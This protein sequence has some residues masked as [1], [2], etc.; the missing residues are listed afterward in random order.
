MGILPCGSNTGNKD[1]GSGSK[2][3]LAA[4]PVRGRLGFFFL[5][6]F[7]TVFGAG[8]SHDWNYV[9]TDKSGWSYSVDLLS[10]KVE[11][12]QVLRCRVMALHDGGGK[13]IDRWRLDMARHEL[14][15]ASTDTPEAILPGSVAER[16]IVFLRERG[17]LPVLES[18]PGKAVR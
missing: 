12:P 4:I 1:D 18:L 5:V 9:T 3:P 17:Q 2:L 15:R 10:V 8:R 16:T 13:V 11:P 6:A 14:T 7:F